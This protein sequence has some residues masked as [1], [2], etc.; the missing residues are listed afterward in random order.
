MKI[1]TRKEALR[2]GLL[3]YFTGNPCYRGHKSERSVSSRGCLECH[4]IDMG[5]RQFENPEKAR[6]IDKRCRDNNPLSKERHLKENHT[7]EQ[8]RQKLDYFTE[9]NQERRELAIGSLTVGIRQILYNKQKGLCNGCGKPL[10]DSHIDHIL[11][12]SRGGTNTDDNVQLL[13]PNCNLSKG[14]KTMKEWKGI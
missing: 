11:A 7:S 4:R 9:K 6:E 1:I 14:V 5:I 3:R 8:W 12:I 10:Q 2:L 13:C